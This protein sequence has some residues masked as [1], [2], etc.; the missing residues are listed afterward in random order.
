MS[1]VS[2]VLDPLEVRR[3]EKEAQKEIRESLS[4]FVVAGY[5]EGDGK[6]SGRKKT[7]V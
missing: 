1:Y 3:I 7:A 4:G 6:Q 2:N 5:T